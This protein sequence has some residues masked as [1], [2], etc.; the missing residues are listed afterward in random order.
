MTTNITEMRAARVLHVAQ[1]GAA[2]GLWK[3]GEQVDEHW[4]ARVRVTNEHGHI[5]FIRVAQRTPFKI[6][7]MAEYIGPASR[8]V[9]PN[10]QDAEC[11]A[12]RDAEKIARDL[13]RR[14]VN[15]P[16]AIAKMEAAR[17]ALQANDSKREQWRAAVKQMEAMGYRLA[18]SDRQD[19]GIPHGDIYRLNFYNPGHPQV[20]MY[21]PGRVTVN[22]E[23][24]TTPERLPELLRTLRLFAAE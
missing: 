20:T 16:E 1:V 2:L 17:A 22:L 7:A 3:L 9:N 18:D 24:T 21:A 12:D 11:S 19:N 10:V 8:T 6:G 4:D 13:S 23:P 15:N 5:F 14:V